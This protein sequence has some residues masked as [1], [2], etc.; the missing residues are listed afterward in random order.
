MFSLLSS[1]HLDVSQEN[2]VMRFIYNYAAGKQSGQIDVISQAIRYSFIDI[3]DL[4]SLLKKSAEIRSSKMFIKLIKEELF[5]RINK[6]EL[7][8]VR[9]AYY[10]GSRL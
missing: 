4:L 9:R 5:A 10:D 1:N 8:E 2:Q 3:D 6:K 7:V